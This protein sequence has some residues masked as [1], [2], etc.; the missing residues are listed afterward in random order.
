MLRAPIWMTSAC[1][2]T[3]SAWWPSSSSVT[4]GSPVCRARLG[5]DLQACDAEPVERE[6][7]RARLE[8]AAA[9]HRRA[10]GGDRARDRRASARA[11]RPCTARRSARRSS[12]PPTARPSDGRRPSAREWASSE[13]ASLYGRRDRDDAVD[14]RHALQAELAHALAGPRSRRSRSSARRAGRARGRRPSPAARGRRRPR[15][16]PPPVSSRSSRRLRARVRGRR[17]RRRRGG[18]PARGA[19]CAAPARAARP[20]RARSRAAACRGR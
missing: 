18:A 19:P 11:T 9:Q 4:T 10:G 3:A 6:R 13:D 20:G 16:R 14:A 8:G 12:P 1:S 17:S 7:R 2:A 15:R 5:E